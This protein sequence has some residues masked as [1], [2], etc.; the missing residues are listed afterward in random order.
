LF[1]PWRKND[2][3]ARGTKL[4]LPQGRTALC[5]VEA[6]E[7]WLAVKAGAR[8]PFFDDQRDRIGVD[9]RRTKAA[10]PA[11]AWHPWVGAAAATA[12][13]AGTAGRH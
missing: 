7:A 11:W 6:L 1:L 12:R 8:G 4:W 5:P 9:R 2:Q 3:D 10:A 13:S